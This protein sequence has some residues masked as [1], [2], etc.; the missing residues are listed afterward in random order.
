MK[1]L[2]QFV[3]DNSTK[4]PFGLVFGGKTDALK[5]K[6]QRPDLFSAYRLF[7]VKMMRL[8]EADRV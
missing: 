6:I 7:I 4:Y 1:T 3:E 5:L 8:Y 2:N